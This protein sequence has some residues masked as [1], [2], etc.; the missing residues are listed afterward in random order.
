MSWLYIIIGLVVIILGVI[1][2]VLYRGY[3]RIKPQPIPGIPCPPFTHAVLGHPDKIMHPF[4]HEFRL[5]LCDVTETLPAYQLVFMKHA[6]V[7]VNDSIEVGRAINEIESKGPLYSSFRYESAIPD[8]ISSDGQ[9][10]ERRN[11]IIS[12][13]LN[14]LKIPSN[15]KVIE[16]LIE[17]LKNKSESGES[18][19]IK[20]LFTAFTLDLLCEIFFNYTLDS[21]IDS[22]EGKS[23][24]S[25]LFTLSDAQNSTGIYV[26]PNA[27]KITPDELTE[28]RATWRSFLLKLTDIIKTSNETKQSNSLVLG[29]IAVVEAEGNGDKGIVGEVHQLIK[30]G[31]EMIAGS[32]LWI[33]FVLYRY[34]KIRAELELDLSNSSSDY[35]ENVIKETYRRYPVSGNM[36]VRTV[37]TKGYTIN[38]VSLPKG[39]PVHLHLWSLHNTKRNW[40]KPKDFIPNRWSDDSYNTPK[41]P[42][43]KGTNSYD[44]VGPSENA[45]SYAPFSTGERI[46]KG[47]NLAL[48]IIR[49]VIRTVA[50]QYHLD[51]SELHLDDEIGV[52]NSSVIIP[53]HKKS[54]TLTVSR[55]TSLGHFDEKKAVKVDEGWASEDD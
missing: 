5:D 50:S 32:L 54:F 37:D 18:I 4:K 43:H 24:I 10:Y 2:I 46:C 45:L 14:D 7:F 25:A 22:N 20:Q 17:I 3:N 8:F 29:I 11:Q 28:A 34:P 12:P 51:P 55:I 36:T 41:C 42:F 13:A 31:Y 38:N 27:R 39:T 33:F 35:L 21:L 48:D 26:L 52:S 53:Y 47:K 44:G 40:D 30:H 23:I 15:S 49:T 19:D 6:S 9:E 1:G 16:N